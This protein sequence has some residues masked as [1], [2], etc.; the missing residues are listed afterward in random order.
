M[1]DTCL[2]LGVK[3]EQKRI[4]DVSKHLPSTDYRLQHGLQFQNENPPRSAREREREC[5]GVEQYIRLFSS[6]RRIPIILLDN[7]ILGNGCFWILA[8]QISCRIVWCMVV[9]FVKLGQHLTVG[10]TQQSL[11]FSCTNNII[12]S[13]WKN[14]ARVK[15]SSTHQ[16]THYPKDEWTVDRQH[17]VVIFQSRSEPWRL[18]KY[19]KPSTCIYLPIEALPTY[20]PTKYTKT[21]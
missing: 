16:C 11:K 7:I 10:L 9:T 19:T 20:V 3:L 18:A 14:P 1:T 21:P 5:H 13:C 12:I 2:V 15:L 17:F 4:P 6:F 8:K